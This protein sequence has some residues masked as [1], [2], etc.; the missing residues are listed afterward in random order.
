MEGRRG[1]AAVV[2]PIRAEGEQKGE[3][4]GVPCVSEAERHNTALHQDGGGANARG[5]SR[6]TRDAISRIIAWRSLG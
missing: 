3:K 4:S 1:H 2:A 6:L 5:F